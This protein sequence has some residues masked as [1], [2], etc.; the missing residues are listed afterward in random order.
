[1]VRKLG[2]PMRLTISP[3]RGKIRF[4]FLLELAASR[5]IESVAFE[6]SADGAMA[7]MVA[8]QGLQATHG[9]AI[10]PALRRPRGP[11]VLSLVKS[12]E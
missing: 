6:T 9:I 7:M 8:L 5:G 2:S 12:D 3:L 10:P 4:Q 11:V 1:M